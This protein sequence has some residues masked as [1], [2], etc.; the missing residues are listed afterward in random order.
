MK[1]GI[2]GT[3]APATLS[4]V[5]ACALLG[6]SEWLGYQLAARSEF[7]VTILKLGARR[8]RI[9]TAALARYLDGK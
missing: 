3:D 6:I 2:M 5:E 7:P 9:P 4:M 1:I 8:I